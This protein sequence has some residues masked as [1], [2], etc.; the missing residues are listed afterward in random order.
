MGASG[1]VFFKNNSDTVPKSI[2]A[3]SPVNNDVR[4]SFEMSISPL[5]V[6]Y[7]NRFPTSKLKIV[8]E[9][10]IHFHITAMELE[11][12]ESRHYFLDPVYRK[13]VYD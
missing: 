11:A 10:I 1:G 12:T 8:N 5:K 7:M 9:V 13:Q 4:D 3:V 2:A 6:R